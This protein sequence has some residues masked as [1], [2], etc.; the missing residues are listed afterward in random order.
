MVLNLHI[1]WHSCHP[2][3]QKIH[4]LADFLVNLR[5]GFEYHPIRNLQQPKQKRIEMRY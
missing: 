5:L 4:D 3:R 1:L 2:Y